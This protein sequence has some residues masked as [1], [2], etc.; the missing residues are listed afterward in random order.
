MELRIEF[1]NFA[2]AAFVA[3]RRGSEVEEKYQ[4][5]S[6]GQILNFL[7]RGAVQDPTRFRVV[8]SL[9]ELRIL[10]LQNLIKKRIASRWEGDFKKNSE[11]IRSHR[12]GAAALTLLLL[13]QYGTLDSEKIQYFYLLFTQLVEDIRQDGQHLDNT[14][15]LVVAQLEHALKQLPL[16]WGDGNFDPEADIEGEIWATRNKMVQQFINANG[17]ETS[18]PD[19]HEALKVNAMSAP[20]S[21]HH[22]TMNAALDAMK[23]SDYAES[24]RLVDEGLLAET[25]KAGN[26]TG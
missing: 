7:Q 16:L 18:V 12:I 26:D 2:S 3:L 17:I 1:E 20:K 25:H 9:W 14:Q 15:T 19:L 5:D 21:Q 11:E 6:V 22:I 10:M 4:L 23:R 8:V 13:G 24:E